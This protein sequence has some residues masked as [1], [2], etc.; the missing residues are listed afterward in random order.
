[1][2]F[3]V[4][5]PP[6]FPAP[7]TGLGS[8]VRV[9]SDQD[10]TGGDIVGYLQRP[11]TSEAY[12]GA[13]GYGGGPN[14]L[15]TLYWG[16]D[17]VGGGPFYAPPAPAAGYD[18]TARAPA[19]VWFEAHNA[20][21]TVVDGPTVFSPAFTLDPVSQGSEMVLRRL[22]DQAA[23]NF[24]TLLA[25]VQA[26]R[27]SGVG[28]NAPSALLTGSGVMSVSNVL[29]V[30]VRLPTVPAHWGFTYE[31]PRRYIPAPGSV[32]FSSGNVLFESILVHYDKQACFAQSGFFDAVH[33][34]FRPGVT[35]QL[36]A[37]Y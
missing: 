25:A 29:G 32:Q 27:P 7:F 12:A 35:G 17:D 15:L 18:P 33:Y 16:W 2:T 1:V 14:V 8:V 3:T 11:G 30:V 24:D 13:R 6:G 5:Y 36:V 34:N 28:F 10:S 21:L 37:F 4:H 22:F 9:S 20:A 23:G 31:A 19:D 26:L